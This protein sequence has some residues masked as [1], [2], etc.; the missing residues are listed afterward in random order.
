M[1]HQ[2]AAV[3]GLAVSIPHVQ[4]VCIP[5][6]NGRLTGSTLARGSQQHPGKARQP[7]GLGTRQRETPAQGARSN[8]SLQHNP[9]QQQQLAV[10]HSRGPEASASRGS[11][12]QSP[13]RSPQHSAPS[14][15]SKTAGPA[16]APAWDSSYGGLAVAL[17]APAQERASRAEQGHAEP[18]HPTPSPA[19]PSRIQPPPVA[20]AVGPQAW[21]PQH[22]SKTAGPAIAPA[23]ASS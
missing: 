16:T 6:H 17:P 12:A 4:G 23:P 9:R 15:R 14:S 2:G 3:R 20:L 11:H 5:I 21:G 18:G 19:N 8:K 10:S 22:Q 7:S 13:R 1:P